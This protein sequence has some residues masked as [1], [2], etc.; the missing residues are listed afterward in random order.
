MPKL[1]D[2][3]IP[4]FDGTPTKWIAFKNCFK[5]VIGDRGDIDNTTKYR[6]LESSCLGGHA[7]SMIATSNSNYETAWSRL[8]DKYDNEAMLKQQLIAEL[9]DISPTKKKDARSLQEFFEKLELIVDQLKSIQID[10][11]Q[12]ELFL[13]HHLFRRL[14]SESQTELER[15]RNQ[16]QLLT[17]SEFISCLKARARVLENLSKLESKF[18]PKSFSTPKPSSS[19]YVKAGITEEPVISASTTPEST[20][21]NLSSLQE[22]ACPV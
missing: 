7:S 4:R 21:K 11:V 3:S 15:S 19:K 9:Y 16:D 22:H 14:D 20:K 8:S 5:S 18:E 1:P 17:L 12:W 6:Y 10:A 13:V 2:L